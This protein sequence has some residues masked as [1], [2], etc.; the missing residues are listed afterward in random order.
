MSNLVEIPKS[1]NPSVIKLLEDALEMAKA[2]E[3][4]SVAVVGAYSDGCTM[5][6]FEARHRVM[7]LLGALRVLEREIMD[8]SVE[9]RCHQ[10]LT[11][12]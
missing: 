8:C 10:P 9:L 2:G 1:P 11:D 6:M 4:I 3:L 7:A 12:Y 5:E